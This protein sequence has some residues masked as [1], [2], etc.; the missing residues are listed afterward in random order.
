MANPA[1]LNAALH[2]QG[3]VFSLY[4]CK[5]PDTEVSEPLDFKLERKDGVPAHTLRGQDFAGR[6]GHVSSNAVGLVVAV[7]DALHSVTLHEF[8]HSIDDFAHFAGFS[9]NLSLSA[10]QEET[11]LIRFQTVFLTETEEDVEFR[12]RMMNDEGEVRNLL[13]LCSPEGTSLSEDDEAFS[14]LSHV[15]PDQSMNHWL[16][17]SREEPSVELE[18]VP[19]LT[20]MSLGISTFKKPMDLTP[21]LGIANMG[22]RSNALMVVQVP[23]TIGETPEDEDAITRLAGTPPLVSKNSRLPGTPLTSVSVGSSMDEWQDLNE[24]DILRDT[25]RKVVLTVVFCHVV[26]GVVPEIDPVL[27]MIEEMEE[28]YVECSREVSWSQL[29]DWDALLVEVDA[30]VFD[31]D[32]FRTLKMRILQDSLEDIGREVSHAPVVWTYLVGFASKKSIFKKFLLMVFNKLTRVPSWVA[33]W[34]ELPELH[35]Q[36]QH[37]PDELQA[38]LGAQHEVLRVAVRRAARLST[39]EVKH[40][41]DYIED[42]ITR[43]NG[44]DL[45]HELQSPVT[46]R[47]RFMTKRMCANGHSLEL[48]TLGVDCDAFGHLCEDCGAEIS[49]GQDVFRCSACQY[50]LCSTCFGVQADMAKAPVERA[51]AQR[52]ADVPIVH[53]EAEAPTQTTAGPDEAAATLDDWTMRRPPQLLVLDPAEI[54]G[55]QGEVPRC[56]RHHLLQEILTTLDGY[57][58]DYCE[59]MFAKGALFRTCE[60]CDFDLCTRCWRNPS[61]F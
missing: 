41:P 37:L 21:Q 3:D 42:T 11:C 8:L 23:V 45:L 7:G 10:D 5:L 59:S 53:A 28:L 25:S 48:Q 4:T 47:R 2:A 49:K 17:A 51:T 52:K 26:R 24:C 22:A 15:V 19:D 38:S 54:P 39:F 30:K 12:V 50:D 33:V 1:E 16:R 55:R 40:S 14:S 57:H 58:C 18:G 13:L 46:R 43:E 35:E 6:F 27:A 44:L 32:F 60:K 34:E 20:G 36:I 56:P 29:C 9:P 61:R 31:V